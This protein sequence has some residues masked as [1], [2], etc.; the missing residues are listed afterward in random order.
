MA[1]NSKDSLQ[2]GGFVEDM[3][4]YDPFKRRVI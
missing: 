1:F 4:R 3:T 2:V